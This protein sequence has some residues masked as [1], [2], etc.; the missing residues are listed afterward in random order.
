MDA[1][2]TTGSGH[3]CGE[4]GQPLP[5]GNVR[6]CPSCGTSLDPM[7]R[8]APASYARRMAG[9]AIDWAVLG[10]VVAPL[11]LWIDA[12][13]GSDADDAA[14]IVV[15]NLLFY[16]APFAYW[17]PFTRWWGGQ[18]IGRRVA[19]VRVVRV[20]DGTHAGYWTGV[21]RSMLVVLVLIPLVPLVV[22]L[23]LPLFGQRRS[24][25]DRATGTMVTRD[26]VRVPTPIV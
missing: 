18:T 13:G 5:T 26:P 8:P 12:P 19:G 14:S 15:A 16:V 7:A 6:F 4:C 3:Y 23:V 21:G 11:W 10:A 20:A 22:D 25:A 9:L 24:L 2:E 1:T 17:A